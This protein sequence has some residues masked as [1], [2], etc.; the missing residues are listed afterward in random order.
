MN[1]HKITLALVTLVLAGLCLLP[2]GC[3]SKG[4]AQSVQ[5][6]CF[7]QGKVLI[8]TEVDNWDTGLAGSRFA[9]N[10]HCL[11]IAHKKGNIYVCNAVCTVVPLEK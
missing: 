4:E 2:A 8:E 11:K 10:G 1:I 5:I 3:E 6:T 9:G 7:Q